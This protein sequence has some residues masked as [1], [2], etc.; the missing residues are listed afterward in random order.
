VSTTPQTPNAPEVPA[1]GQKSNRQIDAAFEEVARLAGSDIPPAE[2]YQQF[3][4]KTVGGIEAPAGA[5]WLRTPQG[6]LQLQCQMNLDGVG[7]D[8]HKGGRQSHNELLRQAFQ[9]SKP[10]L[11]EPYGTTGI[12]EGMPAGNPTEL[13]VLLAPIQADKQGGGTETVGLLEVWQD[14]RWEP[15]A[16]KLCLNY[17]IQMAGYA[18]NFV[19]N[20]QGRRLAGQEQLWTQLE[21]FAREVHASL[22]PTRVA[23]Q[24]A[25]EGRRL[26][27]CDR[28]SVATVE[29]K[30]CKIQAVSGSD[31]VEKRSN[32]IV[33]MRALVDAVLAWGEKLVYTGSKDES[34][35]PDVLNALDD[36]LA[37]SNSK[38][39][40]LQPLRD[41]RQKDV[42]GP[43]RSALLI[44]CFET[45]EQTEP[46]IARLEVVSRHATTGLYNAVELHRIP[47]GWL[48]R[49]V[50]AVQSGLGG[51]KKA[52]ITAIVAAVVGLG[53]ALV[54]VPYPLKMDANGQMLPMDRQRIYA[55]HP[56]FVRNFLVDPNVK[57]GP[58]QG[59]V[60]MEDFQ[61][62]GAKMHELKEQINSYFDLAAK[63]RTQESN[64]KDQTEMQR[65]QLERAKAEAT[66]RAKATELRELIRI[67]NA[68]PN[69]PGRFWVVAPPFSSRFAVDHRP[70][71]VV[72]DPDYRERFN[73]QYVK[74]SD[75]IL[76]LGDVNGN[77][78]VELKIPEK[79]IGQIKRAFSRDEAD[80]KLDVD[81]L[82]MSDPTRTFRG[83][84]YKSRM[85]GEA[86]PNRDD[87][88]ESAPVVLAYVSL[89]DK[90][91]PPSMRVPRELTTTGIE[92][93]GKVRCGKH[94]MGYSLFYGLFE[95]MYE[96][97]V[98]FF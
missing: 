48:W 65:A 71:W 51:K 35:P 16:Q 47:L 2:F 72:L 19:R 23:Y 60:E 93:H 4:Q 24:V 12:H 70:E 81:L 68:D 34:L 14:P 97:V 82:I 1:T 62:L 84:L 10:M 50:A 75:P 26:I 49:P 42:P 28:L 45:P 8:K 21:T 22:D 77:F 91:I 25:N 43:A 80:P 46:L 85:A 37:E 15:R 86:T 96:K 38:L 78:E 55:P 11:L 83:V 7:L 67:N 89:D 39:L 88:N 13:V 32:L 73:N 54:A 79:H 94:A 18:A 29:S 41:E 58:G 44:E 6:F 31:V 87:H 20:Q 61:E 36:F 5:I 92:V 33:L 59:L 52:I 69:R 17:L 30:K 9:M 63:Y 90:S 56:G 40:V 66:Q 53:V 76:R 74:P 64:A 95:F 27:G 98:F 3:L 57:F